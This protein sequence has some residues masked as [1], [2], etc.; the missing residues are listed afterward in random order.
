MDEDGGYLRRG[1]SSHFNREKLGRDLDRLHLV[2]RAAARDQRMF[3]FDTGSNTFL[4]NYILPGSVNLSK[5]E[6]PIMIGTAAVGAE[7]TVKKHL[8][9]DWHVA[10]VSAQMRRLTCSLQK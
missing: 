5:L 2:F 6:I 9:A 3:C 7:L 8:I 10:F 1:G 4:V